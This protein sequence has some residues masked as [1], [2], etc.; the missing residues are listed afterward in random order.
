MYKRDRA[1]KLQLMRQRQLAV[2]HARHA[3]LP[4]DGISYSP[5]SSAYVTQ[6]GVTIKQEIQIPQVRSE[7]KPVVLKG[8]NTKG[9]EITCSDVKS[10]IFLCR[11]HL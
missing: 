2:Q 1:R 9:A 11:C 7:V 3:G 5:N 10:S 6:G 8:D 4:I